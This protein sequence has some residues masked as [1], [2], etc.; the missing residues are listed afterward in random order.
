MILI[1]VLLIL[2]AMISFFGT[3][4][5]EQ[6][7]TD[8]Y[9]E[10]TLQKYA[11]DNYRVFFEDSSAPEDNIL[12]VFLTNDACDGYY[13]IAW[14][15][16]NINPDINKMFGE[17]GEYGDSLNNRINVNYY[18]YSLDTDLANVV[19]D[20]AD[21]I[22]KLG[23]E[24]PFN[25]ESDRSNPGVSRIMNRT[26]LE[27]TESIVDTA[28]DN[29]TE[30]T[31]IPCVIVV[32]NVDIVFGTSMQDV[33]EEEAV[34]QPAVPKK[35]NSWIFILIGVGSVIAVMYLLFKVIGRKKKTASAETE[36]CGK[37]GCDGKVDSD[38]KPPWEY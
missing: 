1:A 3:P 5:V 24:S 14:V 38:T 27:L 26:S 31:G 37:D 34:V 2:S 25:T 15:G 28:L 4:D 12:L 30:K 6:T 20:M 17:Y 35:N 36:K 23:Y 9:N 32:E 18:G 7:Q 8:L 11:D 10:A 33:T 19:D 16:D 29:F 13:T 22:V 21:C